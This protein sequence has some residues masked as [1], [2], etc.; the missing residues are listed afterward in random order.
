[1]TFEQF[2]RQRGRNTSNQQDY[3]EYLQ[4]LQE[5]NLLEKGV[6]KKKLSQELAPQRAPTSISSP[7]LVGQN[8][9][10]GEAVSSFT[11]SD[12]AK[13]YNLN[14]PGGPD[15]QSVQQFKEFGQQFQDTSSNM[16][17]GD[18]PGF[19][20]EGGAWDTSEFVGDAKGVASAGM[21]GMQTAQAKTATQAIMGGAMTGLSVGNM[22]AGAAAGPVGIAVG[23]GTALVGLANASSQRRKREKEA[24]RIKKEQE[25]QLKKIE[26]LRSLESYNKRRQSAYQSLMSA[27]R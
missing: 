22:M 25:E 4:M 24:E 8:L 26:K 7:D 13:R 20:E 12:I 6:S 14:A 2:Q 27:F 19:F 16:P 21:M 23:L 10:A 9:Q 15:L 3:Q 18:T 11:N 1:M 17:T 5:S